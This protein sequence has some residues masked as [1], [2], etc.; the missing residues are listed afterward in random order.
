MAG[1]GRDIV[2][3]VDRTVDVTGI[4]A[5]HHEIGGIAGETSSGKVIPAT[6]TGYVA[7]RTR[8]CCICVIVPFVAVAFSSL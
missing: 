6:Q 3:V 7:I 5:F 1:H 2:E 8:L 4:L